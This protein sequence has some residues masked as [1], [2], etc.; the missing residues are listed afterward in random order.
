MCELRKP[1]IHNHHNLVWS[2]DVTERISVH[3]SIQPSQVL[4]RRQRLNLIAD[5][6][7]DGIFEGAVM[8]YRDAQ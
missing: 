4:L 3:P 5:V 1:A 7:G 6:C 2:K 8:H